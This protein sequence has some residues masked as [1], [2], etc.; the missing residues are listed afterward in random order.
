MHGKPALYNRILRVLGAYTKD[1]VLGIA[2]TEPE[3]C[4][5]RSNKREIVWYPSIG[6]HVRR[7]AEFRQFHQNSV[8]VIILYSNTATCIFIVVKPKLTRIEALTV[9]PK[10]CQL[11]LFTTLCKTAC[12]HVTP[13]SQSP[14]FTFNVEVVT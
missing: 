8:C 3:G 11:R 6:K 13:N 7:T 1:S 2:Y 5:S 9:C 4:N 12:E 14:T 10:Q